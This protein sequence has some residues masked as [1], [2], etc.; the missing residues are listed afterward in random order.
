MIEGGTMDTDCYV[1]C[2]QCNATFNMVKQGKTRMGESFCSKTCADIAYPPKASGPYWNHRVFEKRDF[3]NEP[4]YEI[5]EVYYNDDH[6]IMSMTVH[7]VSPH[8]QSIENLR[9]VLGWMLKGTNVPILIEGEIKFV[10]YEDGDPD[11]DSEFE[12]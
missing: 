10:N 8:G 2:T 11:P 3:H 6:T 5:H 1:N 7:P 9:K 4:Y 12:F